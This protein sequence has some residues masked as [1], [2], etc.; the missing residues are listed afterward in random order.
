MRTWISLIVLL[1]LTTTPFLN[2]QRWW[3]GGVDGE[4][5]RVEKDLQI[6]NFDGIRLTISAN[7]YLTPGRSQSVRVSAQQNIIDLL[8]TDV[9]GGVWKITTEENLRKHSQIKIYIT[10]PEMTY[11]RLSG[12]GDIYTEG[13]FDNTGNEVE[14]GVS[15]S[16]NLEFNTNARSVEASISGS[17]DVEL[18][19]TTDDISLGISGSGDIDAIDMTARNCQVRVSGSGN[20]KVHATQE[21][22]VRVS[23]SGDVYYRG[24]P[25][26]QSRISGSGDLES[27]SGR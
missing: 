3:G 20:V 17:G 13:T 6:D 24:K 25:N 19:G 21:L 11:V 9:D 22:N 15:G 18:G 12:S 26:V 1:S 10:V 2:A 23:G 27:V 7:V 5:P 14:L 16:G 4:G 8:E